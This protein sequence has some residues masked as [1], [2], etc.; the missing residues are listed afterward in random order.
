MLFCPS[1]WGHLNQP[2]NIKWGPQGILSISCATDLALH[3][4]N[5]N[6]DVNRALN[7]L[8]VKVDTTF[9]HPQ[10][11]L[12]LEVMRGNFLHSDCYKLSF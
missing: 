3:I 9:L 7:R 2:I 12:N 10:M 1:K 8:L 11:C 4:R 6:A 5:Y